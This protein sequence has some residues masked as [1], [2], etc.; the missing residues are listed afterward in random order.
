MLN[1]K[2]FPNKTTKVSNICNVWENTEYKDNVDVWVCNN[3]FYVEQEE[4]G[5][6]VF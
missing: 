5:T 1:F 3:G 4:D 6:I 2:C